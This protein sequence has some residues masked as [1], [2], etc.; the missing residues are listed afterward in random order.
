MRFL[1]QC[2]CALAAAVAGSS[3]MAAVQP[4]LRA[5][6]VMRTVLADDGHWW[7]V[8]GNWVR[9]PA[10]RLA[11]RYV[12]AVAESAGWTE[13]AAHVH[14]YL[15]IR[16]LA[17]NPGA[18]G[19]QLAFGMEVLGA[20][21]SCQFKKNVR[22][23]AHLTAVL[24]ARAATRF[25]SVKV[26]VSRLQLALAKYVD[27]LSA[28]G[29]PLDEF[30]GFNDEMNHALAIIEETPERSNRAVKL[31]IVSVVFPLSKAVDA[32]LTAQCNAGNVTEYVHT[33][34][35]Y[36]FAPEILDNDPMV[37]A[38][39]EIEQLSEMVMLVDEYDYLN[40][41]SM[42]NEFWRRI[43]HIQ[44]YVETPTNIERTMPRGRKRN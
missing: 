2:L 30:V 38:E 23:H 27:K 5:A 15:V 34:K 18:T 33:I 16:S 43:L 37:R 22:V 40:V 44:E 24:A 10:D 39:V 21:T 1:L 13:D 14:A 4:W 8:L 3:A 11:D 20:A 28:I 41:S 19:G 17:T 6:D 32:S 9:V 12:R 7:H 25:E 31:D 29:H 42:E 36:N 26:C 35:M